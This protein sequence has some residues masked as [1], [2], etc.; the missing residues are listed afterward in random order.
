MV[1]SDV[2]GVAPWGDWLSVADGAL[3][4][5]HEYVGWDLWAVTQVHG[6]RQIVLR[7]QP[8]GAIPAGT[9]LS[10]EQSFCRQMI[11]GRAPRLATVT[12][13]VPEYASRASGP[14]RDIAAYVGVPLLARDPGTRDME[15]FGTLCGIAFRAKPRTAARELPLVE[16]IARMLN[17][18]MVGEIP[19][20]SPP[21]DEER[22]A[23]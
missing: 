14:I 3:R 20:P 19:R 13:A 23:G 7:V 4:F 22:R 18:M 6:D 17:T 21:V 11:E 1:P 9:A 5:L 10:W 16:L 2:S 15:L 12:A 8:E